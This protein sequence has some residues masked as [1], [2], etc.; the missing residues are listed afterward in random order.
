M[1]KFL[2]VLALPLLLLTG[3]CASIASGT[4][5]TLSFDSNPQGAD[6]TLKREELV[7]GRVKTPST[8]EVKKTKHDI[9]VTCSKDGYHDT[10]NVIDSE[11]EGATFGNLILGGVVGWVIDSS[12]GA[13]NHYDE[14]LTV[15][16]FPV[17]DVKEDEPTDGGES[18]PMAQNEKFGVALASYHD[19]EVALKSW[20]SYVVTYP[21]LAMGR[22]QVTPVEGAGGSSLYHLYG[23]GLTESESDAICAEMEARGDYCQ[24]V[25]L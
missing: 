1:H 13:D 24:A 2:L 21:K 23:V 16:L 18:P 5:Q 4:S 12:T 6:C 14:H 22:A 9:Q 17:G 11:I 7:I 25:Q 10:S 8:V 3:G 15:T 20:D 19:A